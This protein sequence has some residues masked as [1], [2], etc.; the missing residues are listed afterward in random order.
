MHSFM[1][2]KC[3]WLILIQLI[4]EVVMFC[5]STKDDNSYERCMASRALG[6]L[7]KGPREP[8][9]TYELQ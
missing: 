2:V 8:I 4:N 3:G 7:Q 6:S 5:N 1:N 9:R